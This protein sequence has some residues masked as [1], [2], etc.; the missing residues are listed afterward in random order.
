[1]VSPPLMAGCGVVPVTVISHTSD[2][3]QHYADLMINAQREIIFTTNVWEASESSKT[4]V[5]ALRTLSQR[6]ADRNGEK[7]VVK[8]SESNCLS[9]TADQML[10]SI[11]CMIGAQRS[12]PELIRSS[13]R[14]NTPLPT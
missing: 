12:T 2:I 1:M 10:M 4:I 11:Q 7:I 6:V 3:V 5:D 9:G 8:I 14:E 13:A